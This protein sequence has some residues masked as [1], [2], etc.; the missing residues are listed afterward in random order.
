MTNLAFKSPLSHLLQIWIHLEG[1]YASRHGLDVTDSLDEQRNNDQY[2]APATSIVSG[3]TGPQSNGTSLARLVLFHVRRF[4]RWDNRLDTTT[5]CCY[6]SS[7]QSDVLNSNHKGTL[8]ALASMVD[9]NRHTR[10][11]P[12]RLQDDEEEAVVVVDQPSLKAERPSGQRRAQS[13][14]ASSRLH[15]VGAAVEHESA[16]P[17]E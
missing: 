1:L 2:D 16:Q 8:Q 17:P 10:Q 9:G 7:H 13:R 4:E 15:P 12:Q 11:Q 6:I 5:T 3:W 14:L